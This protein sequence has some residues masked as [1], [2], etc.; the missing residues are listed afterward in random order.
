MAR[1]KVGT[2]PATSKSFT[3]RKLAQSWLSRLNQAARQGEGFDEETG[4]PE[5]IL[6]EQQSLTFFDLACQFVDLKWPHAAAKTR[7]SMADAL[8]TVTPILVTTERGKPEPGDFRRALYG[9]A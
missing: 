7:T 4:L 3:H 5:S 2:H 8:A 9:W 6:R 1:W